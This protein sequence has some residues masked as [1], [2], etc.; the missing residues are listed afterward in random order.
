M[1]ISTSL[2]AARALRLDTVSS[3]AFGIPRI[4]DDVYK[5]IPTPGQLFTNEYCEAPDWVLSPEGEGGAKRIITPWPASCDYYPPSPRED[6]GERTEESTRLPV[7]EGC[8]IP[9]LANGQ[10]GDQQPQPMARD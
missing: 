5:C 9:E 3:M 4:D 7:P 6:I 1:E 2:S 8:L 10:S